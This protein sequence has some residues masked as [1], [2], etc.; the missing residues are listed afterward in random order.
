MIE[1]PEEEMEG[2]MKPIQKL[3]GKLGQKLRDAGRRVR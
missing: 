2:T 1:G 3:T